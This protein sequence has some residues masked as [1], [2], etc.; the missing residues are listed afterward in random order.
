[1]VRTSSVLVILAFLV[2]ALLC[3]GPWALADGLMIRAGS[4]LTLNDATLDLNCRDLTIEDLG[5]LDLGTGAVRHCEDL[6]ANA[7]AIIVGTGMISYCHAGFWVPILLLLEE[8]EALPRSEIDLGRYPHHLDSGALF[9]VDPVPLAD[10][11][12]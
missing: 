8:E 6:L 11:Q 7:G 10:R 2:P 3:L 5:T 4:R 9:P 1:M 12:G